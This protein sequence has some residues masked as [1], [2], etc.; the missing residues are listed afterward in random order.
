MQRKKK[1]I[2]T[3][4]KLQENDTIIMD[5]SHLS[6]LPKNLQIIVN[7]WRIF[8]QINSIA[9]MTNYAGTQM[10]KQYTDK[11]TAMSYLSQSKI[12]WPKQKIPHSSTFHHWILIIHRVANC[13]Q[14][15]I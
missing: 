13:G 10:K 11:R 1:T 5:S 15:G 8:F 6:N 3:P 4:T 9:E 12:N 14:D 2:W 7:N